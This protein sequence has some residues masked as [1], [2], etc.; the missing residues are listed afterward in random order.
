MALLNS[1]LYT[2]IHTNFIFTTESI[3][4]EMEEG[5][6]VQLSGSNLRETPL[7]EGCGN[8]QNCEYIACIV[9]IS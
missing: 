7:A 3:K 6:I 4:K 8:S 2:S 1:G 5:T 9:M